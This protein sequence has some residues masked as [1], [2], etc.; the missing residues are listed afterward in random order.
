MTDRVEFRKTLAEN[1][2]LLQDMNRLLSPVLGTLTNPR[3][4]ALA[5]RS[6]QLTT[7]NNLLL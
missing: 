3:D 1:E 6:L 5:I 4:A 2:G 7:T